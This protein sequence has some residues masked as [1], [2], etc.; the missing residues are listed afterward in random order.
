MKDLRFKLTVL[1]CIPLIF[2]TLPRA[3][4]MMKHKEKFTEDERYQ[5]ALRCVEAVHRRCNVRLS[6]YGLENIPKKNGLL[7]Y[8][9]H[10][11]KYDALA[12]LRTAPLHVG[13][14]WAKKTAIQP[15]AIETAT[16]TDSVLI[17]LEDKRDSVRAIRDLINGIKDGRNYLIYPE[18]RYDGNG[19]HML[20]FQ[21]G[22]FAPPLKTDATIVPV[23]IYNSYRA[24]NINTLGREYPE[25]H[26]L[27]PITV[28]EYKGLTKQELAALVKCRIEEKLAER[29]AFHGED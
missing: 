7:F 1:G 23:A 6:V 4:Y 18:G 12:V 27:E 20:D 16:L 10:Q 8:S 5:M 9:N 17:D 25:I 2:Y 22:C 11:G 21:T 29:R 14:L 24:L 28:D 3:R 15:L 26:Y 13:M 19:N